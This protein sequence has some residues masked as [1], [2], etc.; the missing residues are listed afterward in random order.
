MS[1]RLIWPTGRL[2]AV[3]LDQFELFYI[4]IVTFC[5]SIYWEWPTWTGLGMGFSVKVRGDADMVW[6]CAEEG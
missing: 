6:K 4:F 3:S 5:K 1:V 2:S